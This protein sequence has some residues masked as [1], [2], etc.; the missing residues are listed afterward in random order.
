[1]K[2]SVRLCAVRFL[3]TKHQY[4]RRNSQRNCRKGSKGT[5]E[6]IYKE[7]SEV[8]P[9]QVSKQNLFFFQ[10]PNKFAEEIFRRITEEVRKVVIETVFDR[11]AGILRMYS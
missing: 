8:I 4:C 3:K 2:F 9:V 1:M 5:T 10:N 6:E 11:F 7:I